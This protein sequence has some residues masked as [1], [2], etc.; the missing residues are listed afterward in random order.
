MT[1]AQPPENRKR[2]VNLSLD[3]DVVRSARGLTN[4]L[5]RVVEELL[6]DY[7]AREKALEAARAAEYRATSDLWNAFAEQNGSFADQ[8]STL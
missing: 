2:P 5:S 3:E 1:T 7:V 4:N 8:H 6:I